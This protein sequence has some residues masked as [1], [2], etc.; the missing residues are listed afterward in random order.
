M[1]AA[2]VTESAGIGDVAGVVD[3]AT[4][5][6]VY[7]RSIGRRNRRERSAAAAMSSAG[8]R[9]APASFAVCR[10]LHT[11]IILGPS[12]PTHGPIF[13]AMLQEFDD[14][15]RHPQPR[16]GHLEDPHASEAADHRLVSGADGQR[17]D[18][19]L[20]RLSRAVQHHA[21]PGQRRHPLSPRRHARRSHGA[22]RLDDVEVRRRAHLRSAAARAASSAIRRRCRGASS[23]R[24]TR[25]YVAEI[26]DAIGPEKDVPAPDVNTNE[27]MMAWVM[28]TYSMHVGHT[29]HLGRHRQAAR[30]GRLA[31]PPR[32]DRTR[33][34]DRRRANRRST[35]A[36]TSRARRSRSRASATSARSRRSC[37]RRPARRS[38]PSPTGRAA[39]TTPRDSTSRSSAGTR[40][41]AARRSTASPAPSR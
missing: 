29:D 38:S 18:R 26:I 33:R 8:R 40:R 22:G 35:S 32:G 5:S 1:D 9:S 23:R 28:D 30:A 16:A 10:R 2:R 6:G 41:A 19:S 34:D 37:W 27:Q 7:R 39:S 3:A 12:C 20:H 4:S 14:A 11:S 15:A 17:R 21:R 36:S 13:N 31:R 24:S 25:R